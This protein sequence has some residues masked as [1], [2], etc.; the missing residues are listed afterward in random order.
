ML[1]QADG[2]DH[3]GT[4]IL[5][6]TVLFDALPVNASKAIC[7]CLSGL[8]GPF[9]EVRCSTCGIG[10]CDFNG[11]HP[12]CKC[13]KEIPNNIESFGWTVSIIYAEC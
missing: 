5:N 4:G 13:N 11:T 3:Y 1:L 10:E 6:R 8:T 12:I 2:D 9:C 7:S